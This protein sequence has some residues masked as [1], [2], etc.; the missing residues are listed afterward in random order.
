[1][2]APA[3]VALTSAL[4]DREGFRHGFFTRLG[5]VSPAP[6]DTLN[7]AVST[8]D[9]RSRVEA[10]FAL[11]ARWLDVDGGKL[12]C[13]SQVHGTAHRVLDGTEAREDV[14]REEGDI[15][16]SRA[17]GVGCG[18]RTADCV[19]I[20]LACR[21]SGAVA[22][23]H[24]G[25]KGTVLDAAKAGVVALRALA[26]ERA[27]IIAAVGPHIERCCFEVGQDVAAELFASS[28]AGQTVLAAVE[29][30]KS[31][32]DL[33]VIV[34]A[35]LEAAGIARASIDDVHGCTVCDGRRFFSYR[36]DRESSGRMLSAI[37]TRPT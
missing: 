6:W 35:Q 23:I 12:H 33:R 10:N 30:S 31:H 34:R 11:A 29:G 3:P 32:I 37:A 20:L 4:L 26:G 15:T 28:T 5:G 18:I 19:P 13:L 9:D 36:R 25:W 22:A 24:S 14:L 16:V 21:A 17:P 7:F 8:G 2:N 1:M 27:D